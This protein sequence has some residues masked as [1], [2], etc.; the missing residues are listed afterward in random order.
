MAFLNSAEGNDSKALQELTKAIDALA[1]DILKSVA[2][3][4]RKLEA[5]EVRSVLEAPADARPG[6]NTL[7]PAPAAANPIPNDTSTPE[8]RSRSA[9]SIPATSPLTLWV[10]QSLTETP[11]YEETLV[12]PDEEDD[13]SSSL[14]KLFTVSENTNK[15]LQESFLKAIPNQ[16]WRQMREKFGDPQCPPTRVPKLD[17][18]VK[19]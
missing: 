14:N 18:I 13:Q 11:D 9:Q 2:S 3:F 17:K 1:S 10:D 19:D 12:W 7:T 16:A 8:V 4:G 5:L 15:L 6:D